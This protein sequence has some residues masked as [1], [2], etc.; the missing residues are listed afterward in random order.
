M[1]RGVRSKAQLGTTYRTATGPRTTPL[2]DPQGLRLKWP[3]NIGGASVFSR[4]AETVIFIPTCRFWTDSEEDDEEDA[5]W[6]EDAEAF[7]F[8]KTLYAYNFIG[9]S[10][11]RIVPV[12]GQD[13]WTGLPILPKPSGGSLRN[14]QARFA[15]Y[16]EQADTPAP[17][18][19]IKSEFLPMAYQW[20]L[21]LLSALSLI[22]AHNIAYGEIFDE[23]CWISEPSLSIALAGFQGSEF[24]DP[25]R[26]STFPGCFFSG[27]EFSPDFYLS[28]ARSKSQLPKRTFSCLAE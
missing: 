3:I 20:S 22:H 15:L 27:N 23:N 6:R 19:R 13:A 1:A 9:K 8:F 12:L 5:D 24:H 25:A 11:P 16:A 10:H 28:N 21:Q 26:G 18:F 2:T 7:D 17:A 4:D 14:F